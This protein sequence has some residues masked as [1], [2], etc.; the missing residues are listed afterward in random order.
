MSLACDWFSLLADDEDCLDSSISFSSS[1][2]NSLNIGEAASRQTYK[3]VNK[4]KLHGYKIKSCNTS[5]YTSC[6]RYM[7]SFVETNKVL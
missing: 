1:R 2:N 7:N 3:D 4:Q 5:H 6:Q